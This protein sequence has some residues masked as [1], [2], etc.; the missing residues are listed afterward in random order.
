VPMVEGQALDPGAA[1]QFAR[2]VLL[3]VVREGTGRQAALAS[4][5]VLGKTGTAQVPKPGGGYEAGGYISSFLGAAPA[6]RARL[7]VVVAIHRPDP[8]LGY[9]GGTV[10]APAVGEILQE[11]LGYLG[12]PADKYD[13]EQAT[14]TKGQAGRSTTEPL[15]EGW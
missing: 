4:W 12:V 8:K 6:S 5:H 7:V 13:V 14:L 15:V 2:G 1:E 3:D 9:Y 11:S 10:A